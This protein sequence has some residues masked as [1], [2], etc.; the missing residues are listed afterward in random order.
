M[1]P[2]PNSTATNADDAADWSEVL[3]YRNQLVATRNSQL[4]YQ[5]H[6]M[7]LHT[8][9]RQ[10]CRDLTKKDHSVKEEVETLALEK[11]RLAYLRDELARRAE[12]LA[13]WETRVRESD[14]NLKKSEQRIDSSTKKEQDRMN[15]ALVEMEV[16]RM[17]QEARKA[18]AAAAAAAAREATRGELST[19]ENE[20]SVDEPVSPRRPLSQQQFPRLVIGSGKQGEPV[21][22]AAG[23]DEQ[24]SEWV[25]KRRGNIMDELVGTDPVQ[26]SPVPVPIMPPKPRMESQAIQTTPKI[27]PVLLVAPAVMEPVVAPPELISNHAEEDEPADPAEDMLVSP[28]VPA[29]PVAQSPPPVAE[30]VA[31]SASTPKPS[32]GG[33]ASA[34]RS[35]L[36]PK[37]TSPVPSKAPV[38]KSMVLPKSPAASVTPVALPKSPSGSVT[39]KAVSTPKAAVTPVKAVTPPKAVTP[40]KIG[41]PVKAAASGAVTPKASTTPSSTT[42]TKAGSGL[43]M[44]KK[45]PALV[46]AAVAPPPLKAAPVEAPVISPEPLVPKAPAVEAIAPVEEP[47]PALVTPQ[48]RSGSSSSSSS[49]VHSGAS[50]PVTA[51]VIPRLVASKSALR[52]DAM[53]NALPHSQRK[54]ETESETSSQVPEDAEKSLRRVRKNNRLSPSR[55]LKKEREAPI[56]E[57][58]RSSNSSSSAAVPPMPDYVMEER[59]LQKPPRPY[60]QSHSEEDKANCL[61]YLWN[62]YSTEISEAEIGRKA[63]RLMTLPNMMR[64]CGDA[65]FGISTQAVIDLYL[66]TAK[67]GKTRN[68]LV[69]KK[70]FYALL[71]TVVQVSRGLTEKDQI[72]EVAFSEFLSPLMHRLRMMERSLSSKHPQLPQRKVY[73]FN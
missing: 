36:T 60:R 42:P 17:M 26:A 69:E 67:L 56:V 71:S 21:T 8:K 2:I 52:L 18:A 72:S 6:M 63:E 9:I 1:P 29:K 3:A 51:K 58:R 54:E 20:E 40:V 7:Q 12:M 45:A 35:L 66:R 50:T 22:I 46:K 64:L 24:M 33:F 73:M 62:E 70:Y 41:T 30:A 15:A 47:A 31:E 53:L 34:F 43:L 39:P 16:K 11:G 32:S 27:E 48:S 37:S 10:A 28:A 61:D 14:P 59:P 13:R 4:E 49:A 68:K 5:Q 38:G 23:A 65:D 25:V 55:S 57:S 44:K 19:P